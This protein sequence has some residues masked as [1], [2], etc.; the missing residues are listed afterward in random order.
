M[1][2]PGEIF[3]GS[4]ENTLPATSGAGERPIGVML[5][6]D[7][8]ATVTSAYSGRPSRF[9]VNGTWDRTGNIVTVI[10]GGQ[11]PER[12]VFEFDGKLVAKEWDRSTWGEVGPGT[13]RRI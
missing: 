10:I 6:A 5:A 8:T 4:Y 12:I 11:R 3:A 7:R 2:G 9:L 1:I 13:L